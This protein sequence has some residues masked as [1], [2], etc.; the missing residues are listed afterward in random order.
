[1]FDVPIDGWYAW[2]GVATVSVALLATATS[3]PTSAPPDAGRVGDTLDRVSASDHTA[4][5]EIPLHAT[6]LRLGP[7][8]L[9]LRNEAGTARVALA[10]GPVTPVDDGPLAALLRGAIPARHFDRPAD[11]AAAAAAARERVTGWRDVDGPLVVRRLSWGDVRV[12]LV[13]V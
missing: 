8:R 11:L 5:A 1:M 2:L 7:H 10:F 6:R 4:T 9:A 3:L 13:G 12:T